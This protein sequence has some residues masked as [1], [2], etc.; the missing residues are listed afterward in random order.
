LIDNVNNSSYLD[1]LPNPNGESRLRCRSVSGR[2]FR[3]A[4]DLAGVRLADVPRDLVAGLSVAALAVPHGM[5]YALVAGVP[6]EMGI[7]AAALPAVVAA[8][9]GS[10]RFLVTGP[11]NPTA[12]LLGAS[13]VAPASA[14][15]AGLPLAEVLAAALLSGLIVLGFGLLRFGRAARF[16]ADPVVVAFATGVGALIALAQLP[17]LL[18]T[19][20]GASADA[21][22]LPRAWLL[23]RAAF[24]ALA[25]ADVRALTLGLGVI[26]LVVVLRRLDRRIPGAL[27]ALAAAA[28]L[29]HAL[30]W[31]GGEHG[32]LRVGALPSAALAFHAP[33]PGLF[34]AVAS[35][36][37]ALAL[38]G[39]VQTVTAVRALGAPPGERVD[40]DREL[41]AQGAASVTAG[42]VGA[43]P[44]AGSLTRSALLKGAGGR[45]RLAALT[46]GVVVLAALPL[47][48]A[49]LAAVPLAALAGLVVLSGLELFDL[50]A[51]RR[52][53]LTRGDALILA[54]TLAATLW[55]DLVQAVYVG[56][57][58]SMVLLIRRA[59][60][61]ELLELVPAGDRYREIPVDGETGRAPVALLNV[62]GDLSFAVASELA[63]SLVEIGARGARVLVVRLKRAH[64][65]DA[66]ALEALRRAAAELG[67]RG[68]RVL[69]CGLTP[70]LQA[71]LSG[72]ELAEELGEGGL[73][74]SGERLAEGLAT[75]LTRA[76][77]LLTSEQDA[78]PF[79]ADP[80]ASQAGSEVSEG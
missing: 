8:L 80:G 20:A 9:L 65:L 59:G 14:A 52:A 73:V 32:L 35:T 76:R 72:S 57:F 56:L 69:L 27:L 12:L 77:S 24:A 79:R 37:F 60:R 6:Q 61:L 1:V 23:A 58:F 7:L 34:P 38:L 22:L 44:T 43:L 47:L 21:G 53:S 54:A 46:S 63:D 33:Q 48:A 75:A 41:F 64:H 13:L 16:L 49:G 3:F 19:S 39:S 29:A 17:L 42:L 51:L 31:T 5:A 2:P 50:R 15:G 68:T 11:T 26:G 4:P 18:G 55:I 62:E 45:S 74:P 28:L 36:A 66:T 10:S 30:G 70:R 71:P 67:D 25:V 78:A 40:S